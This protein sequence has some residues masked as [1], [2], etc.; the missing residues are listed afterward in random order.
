MSTKSGRQLPD[1]RTEYGRTKEEEGGGERIEGRKE[2]GRKEDLE[3]AIRISV[4]SWNDD[5]AH[6]PFA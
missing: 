6:N 4:D 3:G 5:L 1:G 2:E